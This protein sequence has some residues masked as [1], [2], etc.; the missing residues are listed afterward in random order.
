MTRKKYCQ[1]K[2]DSQMCY[3]FKLIQVL[4]QRTHRIS[5]SK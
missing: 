3:K 5:S 2:Y 1:I 4:Q